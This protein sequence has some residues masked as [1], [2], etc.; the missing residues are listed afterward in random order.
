MILCKLFGHAYKSIKYP[1]YTSRE[2][3]CKRCNHTNHEMELRHNLI[4]WYSY[5]PVDSWFECKFCCLRGPLIKGSNEIRF[6]YL[7][8]QTYEAIE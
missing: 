2:C 1:L 3:K 4:Q 7:F 6:Y 8:K 5:E